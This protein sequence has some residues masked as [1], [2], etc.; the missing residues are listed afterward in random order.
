MAKA[1]K[2]KQTPR[3]PDVRIDDPPTD[4]PVRPPEAPARSTSEPYGAPEPK[5]PK[6]GS[7]KIARLPSG[8]D[9]C[10]FCDTVF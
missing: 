1:G 7:R 10:R 2:K 6:C 3:S 4:P 5:C 9:K 8:Q